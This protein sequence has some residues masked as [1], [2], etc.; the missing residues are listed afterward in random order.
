MGSEETE[1]KGDSA[2]GG[3]IKKA[4]E[5]TIVAA[6]GRTCEFL[7]YSGKV[8]NSPEIWVHV[9]VEGSWNQGRQPD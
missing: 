3:G 2:K 4:E 5:D 1:Q 7:G 8:G 9:P 6:R